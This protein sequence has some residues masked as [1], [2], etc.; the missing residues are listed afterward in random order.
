MVSTF[1]A[2]RRFRS[3][4]RAWRSCWRP[5]RGRTAPQPTV[6]PGPKRHMNVES[7]EAATSDWRGTPASPSPV[8]LR[9][10]EGRPVPIR[11]R[12]AAR[13]ARA[14][15]LPSARPCPLGRGRTTRPPRSRPSQ[16]SARRRRPSC[17]TSA[18][19]RWRPCTP[20]SRDLSLER[21]EQASLL[22]QRTRSSPLAREKSG[23]VSGVTELDDVDC[24]G[25]PSR[26][27]H[28]SA[29]QLVRPSTDPGRCA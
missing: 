6:G 20:C 26:S 13:G 7:D 22:D 27:Q 28:G 5:R 18:S 17:A 8:H 24:P 16:R 10:H 3:I 14:R 2:S 25:S 1:D 4:E 9:P 29:W 12:D 19:T 21:G 11:C 15:L 23:L